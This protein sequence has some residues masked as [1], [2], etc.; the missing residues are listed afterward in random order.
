[1]PDYSDVFFLQLTKI[2]YLKAPFFGVHI[3]SLETISKIISPF[4]ILFSSNREHAPHQSSKWFLFQLHC[5]E[6]STDYV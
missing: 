6:A 3:K 1:M 2:I 5:M 4:S